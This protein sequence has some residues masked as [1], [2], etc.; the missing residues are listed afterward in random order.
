M[1]HG[2]DATARVLVNR[3]QGGLPLVARPYGVMAAELETA[4]ERVIGLLRHLLESGVASRFGPS[5]DASRL[6]GALTLAA[7]EVP[8]GRYPEVQEIVNAYPEVAHNYRRR[9][10]LNM[11]FVVATAT[12]EGIAGVLDDIAGRTGLEVLDLPKLREFYLGLRLVLEDDGSVNTGHFTGSSRGTDY[13]P[14]AADWRLI[15]ALQAGMP[16]VAEPWA[17]VARTTGLTEDEVTTRLEAFLETGVVRRI[18]ILPNHY[19]LGLRAN[20][21]SVWDVDDEDLDALGPRIGGF[22]FVSH[23][24]QRPRHGSRWPYNLFAMV[25]GGDR[26]EVLAKTARIAAALEDDCRGHDVLFSDGILKKTGFR[27]AT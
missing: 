26:D 17:E 14:D 5:F 15:E 23:C 16:L 19:R 9:H 8:Q 12:P 3:Y 10:R 18:G 7:L 24:Y 1:S 27:T 25:H 20:G 21:M 13:T 11:W 22:E 4:E 2:L 6:G